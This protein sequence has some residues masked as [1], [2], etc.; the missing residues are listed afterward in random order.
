MSVDVECVATGV[1]HDARDVCL[2][3][4]VNGNERVL[5]SKKVK[6]DKPIVSHLTPIT[7]VRRGD[8]DDGEKLSDVIAEVKALLG[9]NVVLVG[10]GIQSDIEWLNLHQGV[11]YAEAVNVADMFKTYN[12][13]YGN[14]YYYSLSHEANILIQSGK[15]IV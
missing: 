8:L 4:V 2:V 3:A 13:H 10:Q 9:Y 6:P 5:L 15:S 12:I 7:G 1:R 11:D 14:Y